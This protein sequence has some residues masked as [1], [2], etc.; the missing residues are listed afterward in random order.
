MVAD[1]KLKI[2]QQVA[3]LGNE[4]LEEIHGVL[5]NY[6]RGQM[7]IDRW[8]KLRELQQQGIIDAI[9][10]IGGNKGSSHESVIEKT[11]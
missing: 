7:G 5:T 11:G 3:S 8:D 4:Q 9:K 1:L 10:K 6:I 2:F